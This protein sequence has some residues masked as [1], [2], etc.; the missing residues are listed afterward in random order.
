MH[1][2]ARVVLT[3]LLLVVL[4]LAPHSRSDAAAQAGTSSTSAPLPLWIW[5][6]AGVRD[7]ANPYRA[8]AHE[9]GAGHRGIDMATARDG[10][11]LAPADGIVAFRGTVVD[12]PL[13]TI[14]HSGGYVSTFEPLDSQLAPG[15]LVAAGDRI[16]TVAVGGHA[17]PGTLHLGVRLNG[18]YLN[19]MILFGPV[20]RAVLLPCCAPL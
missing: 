7:V 13:L 6:V 2:R 11:V 14:E 3:V 19:P 9:Y 20:P 15:D 18:A 16:G 17:L 4:A 5:P 12:R 1:T 10:A 8:P